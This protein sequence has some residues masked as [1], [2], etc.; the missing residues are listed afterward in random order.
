MAQQLAPFPR[1]LGMFKAY[2]APQPETLVLKE[3][4]MSLSG[5]SFDIKTIDGRP[6]F[7]VQGNAFS[8]SGRKMVMDMT[9][10]QLFTIR[11]RHLR[12]HATYYAEDPSE[13]EILQVEGKFSFGSSKSVATFTGEG[14]RRESLF[15]KGDF[16]DRKAS[17][18]DEASG[19]AVATI[20]RQFLNARELLGGQQTYHV[21]V[22][23]NVDMA[24]IVAMCIC[25]DE[26]R[27]EK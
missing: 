3:K 27:N 13:R 9:G 11:K 22:A 16:F 12:L 2:H 4:I 15:M 21:T 25:L 1:S 7:K 17:I 26:R 19:Q 14:G 18:T 10:N 5:D 23:P 6:V 24:L 8:L 20:N